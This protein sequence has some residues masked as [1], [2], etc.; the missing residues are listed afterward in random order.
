MRSNW[1]ACMCEYGLSICVDWISIPLILNI[2]REYKDLMDSF[3]YLH[4]HLNRCD[5]L[6]AQDLFLFN[7][8]STLCSSNHWAVHICVVVYFL[9][10]LKNKCNASVYSSFVKIHLALHFPLENDLKQCHSPKRFT[11]FYWP[12]FF[13]TILLWGIQWMLSMIEKCDHL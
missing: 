12:L 7:L 4:Q 3:I 1:T 13:N 2:I 6:T 9:L 5:F 11:N 8:H 10:V